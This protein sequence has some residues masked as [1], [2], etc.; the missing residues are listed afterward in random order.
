MRHGGRC[1]SRPLPCLAGL[2]GFALAT[3]SPRDVQAQ[4]DA[5]DDRGLFLAPYIWM[6]RTSGTVGIGS[7]LVEVHRSAIEA[8]EHF[9]M[10]TTLL[11][12]E[13]RASW[14]LG[15][16]V[17]FLAFSQDQ[18]GGLLGSTVRLDTELTMLQPQGGLPILR[19]DW[20]TIWGIAG[21]R[22]W[23]GSVAR[24]TMV[25]GEEID[26][27]DADAYWVD[28]I[29][30]LRLRSRP[31]PRWRVLAQLDAGGGASQFTWEG[32]AGAGFS[33]TRRAALVGVLRYLMVDYANDAITTNLRMFGPAIGVEVQF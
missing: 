30:G 14:S 27:N 7:D 25:D 12:E 31:H 20:G 32:V 8:L 11:V 5:R 6:S 2:V 22:Y 17:F 1:R 33:F 18:P 24:T 29:A 19:R 26:A 9:D 3:A 13:R 23:H 21:V 10:A 15:L 16:D 28:G 4:R